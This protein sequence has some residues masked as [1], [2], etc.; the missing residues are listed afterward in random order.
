M[1]DA[2]HI[3]HPG[4]WVYSMPHSSFLSCGDGGWG[5]KH[6]AGG[7][8][9][10]PAFSIKV[11]LDGLEVAGE[12]LMRAA[13]QAMIGW[14][15]G[16]PRTLFTPMRSL[17]EVAALPV[18]FGT[19]G[20]VAGGAAMAAKWIQIC[21]Y[22]SWGHAL[23]PDLQAW[24]AKAIQRTGSHL[25]EWKARLLQNLGDD[26]VLGRRLCLGQTQDD[27]QAAIMQMTAAELKAYPRL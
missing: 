22:E 21:G 26:G 19:R 2:I 17:A 3:V 7:D 12:A 18:C 8:A 13:I 23:P 25:A 15:L 20:G 27:A 16:A 1:M 4:Y 10:L 24:K 11:A 14:G 9:S 5:A 6:Q